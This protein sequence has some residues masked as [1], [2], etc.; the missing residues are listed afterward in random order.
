MVQS[1]EQ[2]ASTGHCAGDGAS[3]HTVHTRRELSLLIRRPEAPR[4]Q[5]VLVPCRI[6]RPLLVVGQQ[7]LPQADE[8]VPVPVPQAGLAPQPHQILS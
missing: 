5:P 6:Q 8:D 3:P 1:L 4:Q 2:T 7:V